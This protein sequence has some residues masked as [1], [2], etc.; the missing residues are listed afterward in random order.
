MDAI[1]INSYT[2]ISDV[3]RARDNELDSKDRD[4][5]FLEQN[6]RRLTRLL[7]DSQTRAARDERLGRELSP[8]L[9]KEIDDFKARIDREQA[10]IEKIK[11]DKI[12]IV[13]R[14][15][16]SI[17]RFAELKAAERLKAYR[18]ESEEARRK[19]KSIY[20]CRGANTCDLV[21]NKA[22][23]FA[24]E[25]STVELAWANETTIMMRKPR[26]DED[27]SIVLT[28]VNTNSRGTSASIVLEVRCNKSIKGE[29]L[30][31]SSKIKEIHEN[32]AVY[33]E[34]PSSSV[35]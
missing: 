34:L 6:I 3:E 7:E 22:L 13:E 4:I 25:Y 26:E 11:Q 5:T 2:D 9:L 8:K 15:N 18:N 10:Q 35:S 1:L 20:E 23:R 27:V 33:L 29:E 21:W 14:Y 16:N 17:V 28:R 12:A 32:F 19:D 24:S 31:R 30:C